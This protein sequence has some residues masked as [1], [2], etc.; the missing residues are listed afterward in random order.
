MLRVPL[1]LCRNLMLKPQAV[2]D[3]A[4][5]LIDH[6]CVHIG[7]PDLSDSDVLDVGCGV[8][9]TQAFLD[10]GVPVKHYTGVDVSSEV[11]D[12]LQQNVEDPRFEYHLLDAHNELYNPTGSPLADIA[13]DLGT[14][15]LICLFSVFTHLAP[16]DYQA[17][18]T[19]LRRYAGP[20]TRLFYTLFLNEKTDDGYGLIDRVSQELSP[21]TVT[22]VAQEPFVDL[23]PA[24]PLAWAVYS[25]DYAFELI[26]GTGWVVQNVSPPGEHL[27]H[28]IVCTP[29]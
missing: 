5:W 23:D 22:P 11:I 13:L 16:H 14:F 15:D 1:E 26:D 4:V 12:W 10:R 18:L 28:H 9:F 24:Q 27:Q 17:M 8:R 19:L 20:D 7:I 25:R 6:M 2:V 3:E 21:A 29:S